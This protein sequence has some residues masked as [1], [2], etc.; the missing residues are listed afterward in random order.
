MPQRQHM[1]QLPLSLPAVRKCRVTATGRALLVIRSPHAIEAEH[2]SRSGFL[3][4][5]HARIPCS[6]PSAI[7]R[8]QSDHA[9]IDTLARHDTTQEEGVHSCRLRLCG[10]TQLPSTAGV[11][12]K[13]ETL[14]KRLL[15]LH[16]QRR[17]WGC[18]LRSDTSKGAQSQSGLPENDVLQARI[19]QES[20]H[21]PTVC[22]PRDTTSTACLHNHK[23]SHF[24]LLRY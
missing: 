16:G 4:Q 18:V 7:R 24:C 12:K 23:L 20:L 10:L 9:G 13:P 5:E 8:N 3:I 1:A 15:E 6:R 22:A 17:L 2:C 21:R 19:R 14:G 11:F